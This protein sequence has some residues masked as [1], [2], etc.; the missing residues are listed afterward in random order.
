MFSISEDPL[1]PESYRREFRKP[2]SGALVTFEGL[3]RN[4]NEGR[5]VSQ[6]EYEAYATMAIPEG[7]KILAEAKDKF[8]IIESLCVHRVGLLDIGEMAVWIGVIAEHRKAAF[9]ALL[10]WKGQSI[11]TR[12]KH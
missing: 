3:V 10:G 9:N 2:N 6:L 5:S 11:H 1:T 7:D 12:A 8:E 4:V